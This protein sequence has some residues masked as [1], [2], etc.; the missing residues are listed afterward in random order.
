MW[1]PQLRPGGSISARTA[2]QQRY[3]LRHIAIL[4]VDPPAIDDSLRTP[5]GETLLGCH[6]NK[7][8]RPLIQGCV[9]SDERKQPGAQ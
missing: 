3:P 8:V 4:E 5:E 6:R 2:A 7:L 9:V 1:H